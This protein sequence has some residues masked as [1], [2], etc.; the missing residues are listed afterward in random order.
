M[1]ERRSPRVSGYQA[2][3][4]LRARRHRPGAGWQ[5]AGRA[6]PSPGR[7]TRQAGPRIIWRPVRPSS[8]TR[9]SST[10]RAASGP[11][12]V[13][14]S[15]G[16]LSAVVQNA[17]RGQG[18]LGVARA[19]LPTS[20]AD[21]LAH[22]LLA[23]PRQLTPMWN[24]LVRSASGTGAIARM[25]SA[26]ARAELAEIVRLVGLEALS[27]QSRSSW[28][29]PSRFARTWQQNAFRDDQFNPL[30]EQD[31]LLHLDPTS[32][33]ARCGTAPRRGAQGDLRVAG[34]C[35]PVQLPN[36]PASSS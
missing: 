13:S 12:S 5:L 2:R 18:V 28:R 27:P 32:T 22:E 31:S 30:A 17:A 9:A 7:R 1:S 14:G 15:S 3:G 4:V 29:R 34:P 10:A 24:Q 35:R 16:D 33:S 25:S 23:V 19:P 26:G 11:L 20:V 21:R 36:R 8:A 6:S